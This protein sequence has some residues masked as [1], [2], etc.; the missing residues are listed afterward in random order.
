MRRIFSFDLLRVV[1]II[2]VVSLHIDIVAG[3]LSQPLQITNYAIYAVP[4]FLVLSFYLMGKY[5]LQDKL[6][7]QIILRRIKRIVLP[8]FF[9]S[10][11]GFLVHSDLI[12]IKNIVIQIATGGIV[13]TPLVYLILLF[14]FTI[15]FW[16]LT[17]VEFKLRVA[18]YFILIFV[19]FSMQ[20][21]SINYN[22]FSSTPFAVKYSYGRIAE[23]LPYAS[24]GVLLKLFI[25]KTKNRP[26][27][28]II[29]ILLASI[30]YLLTVNII[31]PPG[32]YL[33]RIKFFFGSITIFSLIKYSSKLSFGVTL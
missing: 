31:Q 33:P 11:L 12:N 24:L 4:L 15:L 13:N 2:L 16:L 28:I 30:L 7:C 14:I 21:S 5:F 25:E 17:F 23:L 22:L 9:W 19:A 6:S 3:K 8:L 32:F 26:S 29:L 10:I 18:I 1:L 27:S 20:Y